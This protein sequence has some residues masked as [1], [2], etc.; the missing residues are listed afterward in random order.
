[1]FYYTFELDDASKELCT[2]STPFGL[3]R[4]CKLPMGVSQSPDITQELIEKT[5]HGIDGVEVY[6]D[7]VTVF[8]M[9]GILIYKLL[10]LSYSA[11]RTTTLP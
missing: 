2:I 1:M 7:D 11:Y 10:S 5:L 4:Y 6:F 8:L 3:Y 9:T